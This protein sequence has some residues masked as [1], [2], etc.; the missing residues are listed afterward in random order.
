MGPLVRVTYS[1]LTQSV[2]RLDRMKSSFCDFPSKACIQSNA[3]LFSSGGSSPEVEG[4]CLTLR[5][6]YVILR[7]KAS[8]Y[9][10]SSV[11]DLPCN[12]SQNSLTETLHKYH[13]YL[14]INS[15]KKCQHCWIQIQDFTEIYPSRVLIYY[16]IVQFSYT[17][18]FDTTWCCCVKYNVSSLGKVSKIVFLYQE[19]DFIW[20]KYCFSSCFFFDL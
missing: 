2:F 5:L 16:D 9:S 4:F 11:H 18:V 13:K 7:V 10:L 8:T 12:K 17:Y 14:N 1:S 20:I 19:R 15:C 3:S 6:V